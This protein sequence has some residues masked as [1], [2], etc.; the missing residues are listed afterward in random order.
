MDL[1]IEV[2]KRQG[3][4]SVIRVARLADLVQ[5]QKAIERL[6]LLSPGEHFARDPRTG[7]IILTDD[8]I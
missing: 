8:A 5:A 1:S 7:N 4:G 3:N 6:K 2:F